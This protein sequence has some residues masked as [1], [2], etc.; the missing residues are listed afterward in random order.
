[1][2]GEPGSLDGLSRVSPNDVAA[3]SVGFTA[4]GG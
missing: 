2:N 3:L 4:A 1:M